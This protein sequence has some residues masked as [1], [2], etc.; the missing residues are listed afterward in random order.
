MKKSDTQN[1]FDKVI[2]ELDNVPIIKVCSFNDSGNDNRYSI[3]EPLYI[4]FKNKMALIIEYYFIDG[5]SLEYR[6]LT[7][8]EIHNFFTIDV[9]DFFNRTEEI[10]DYNTKNIKRRNSLRFSYDVTNYQKS[11]HFSKFFQNVFYS[12]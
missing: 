7:E 6:N 5:L 10:Y 11:S 8:E 2:T 1:Y 12:M 3:D 4:I 9:R